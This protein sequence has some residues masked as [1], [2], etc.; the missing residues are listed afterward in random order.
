MSQTAISIENLGK[1]YQLHSQKGSTL[2]SKLSGNFG[3]EQDSF[4]AL[5]NVDF[6]VEEGKVL[7]LVGPNGAGKSTL[8]K[9]LSRITFPTEGRFTTYGR[10]SSLLE[11]G[12]GFHPE[13]SGMDNIYLNGS[14]LGMSKV[15]IHKS[16][17]EIIEFS[18]VEKFINMPVKHYSSG[19]KVR[20]AF[21]V[22]AHLTAEI[23]LIDEVLAVGDASFQRK[24]IERMENVAQNQGRTILF[25]SH[26]MRAVKDLCNDAIYIEGGRVTKSGT[27]EEITQ[28]YSQ[29]LEAKSLEVDLS[30]RFDR[31]GNG[32]VK[33][34]RMRFVSKEGDE[35][36]KL[37]PG[38]PAVLEISYTAQKPPEGLNVRLSIGRENDGFICALSN[39]LAGFNFDNLSKEGVLKCQL[40]KVPFMAGKYMVNARLTK[41]N[42]LA[43]NV[44]Y[45]MT[46]E[47]Q[48]GD[49]FK[50]GDL[51]S[52]TR[53]GVYIPQEWSAE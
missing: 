3:K 20:L 47:V 46:F 48:E 4:W 51:F 1:K 15:D 23:L 8:L 38:K 24:C 43:D 49:Y 40:D 7:G 32:S 18:G 6:N 31:E 53:T 2:F 33:L 28:F 11:V 44:K 5:R 42:I 39:H 17:D 35:L 10:V 36:T 34:T 13:L 19:M 16:L 45:A 27:A 30:K 26:N 29:S 41:H 12:T 14:I 50:S 21:S 22:A 37:T 9:L 52:T 25:V